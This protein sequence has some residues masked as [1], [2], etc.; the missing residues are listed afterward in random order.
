MVAARHKRGNRAP[1]CAGASRLLERVKVAL[2]TALC[3]LVG[4]GRGYIWRR[5]PRHQAS[6]PRSRRDPISKPV[7]VACD[8]TR[9]QVTAYSALI[10]LGYSCSVFKR[11]YYC[12]QFGIDN[13]Q[14]CD[15]LPHPIRSIFRG[16]R[17]A[18]R[19]ETRVTYL[20][21]PQEKLKNFSQN[22]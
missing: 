12:L 4:H 7:L 13:R 3:R 15:N 16:R 18:A 6:S 17:P 11:P 20:A 10:C 2:G 5:A 19:I 1:N 21:P 9:L 14:W 22:L 8:L